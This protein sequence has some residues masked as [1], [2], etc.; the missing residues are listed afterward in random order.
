MRVMREFTSTARRDGRWWVVQC[1]QWPGAI[2]QGAPSSALKSCTPNPLPSSPASPMDT[3][4]TVTIRVL[5]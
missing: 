2:S 3:I 4:T 1:D 5:T